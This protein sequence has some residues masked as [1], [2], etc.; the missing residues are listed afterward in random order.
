VRTGE[1][2]GHPRPVVV[3]ILNLSPTQRGSHCFG[4]RIAT[5]RHPN[6]EMEVELDDRNIDRKGP[7]CHRLRRGGQASV[8]DSIV[9]ILL[10]LG[11]SNHVRGI[12][13]TSESCHGWHGVNV[14]PM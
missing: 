3:F 4:W 9:W 7:R 12:R 10:I 8:E 1:N 13:R 11:D 5:P 14:T 6:L 2:R